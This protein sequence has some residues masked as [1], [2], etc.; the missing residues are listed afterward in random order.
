MRLIAN[1]TRQFSIALNTDGVIG[2]IS[3]PSGTVLNGINGHVDMHAETDLSSQEVVM[4]GCEAY[5]I[6]V[7]D[8][9]TAVTFDALWDRFVPKDTDT[10]TM[11]LD[12]TAVDATPFWE[13]GETD[14]SEIFDLGVRPVRLFRR[15]RMFTPASDRSWMFLD[16]ESPFAKLWRARDA[17]DIKVKKR[18]RV[19]V[20]SVV[21]L[22]V[23]SPSTD[24]TTATVESTLLENEWGQVKY[25]GETLTRAQ[26][27]LLGLGGVGGGAPFDVAVDLLQKHLDPD[28]IEEDAD[29][30]KGVT[31]QGLARM[32]FDHTVPGTMGE[33]SVATRN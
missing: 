10:Q 21:V 14:W 17:F 4:Y 26:L 27:S 13:P 5:V 19:T 33:P 23:G 20:P 29:S 9:D 8:P 32:K 28:V 25:M 31:W 30:F 16:T 3:L 12:T 6:P 2:G 7:I 22:A 11:D 18:V 24:D 1:R 15:L